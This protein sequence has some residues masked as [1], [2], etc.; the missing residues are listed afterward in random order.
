MKKNKIRR[1]L[2]AMSPKTVLIGN[3]IPKEYFVTKGS[4]ESDITVHA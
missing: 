4:G 2:K 1:G 3:R